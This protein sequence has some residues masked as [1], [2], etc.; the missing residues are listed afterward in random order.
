[1]RS[2]GRS[3][4][5][6]DHTRVALNDLIHRTGLRAHFGDTLPHALSECG[7]DP[8]AAIEMDFGALIQQALGREQF[9]ERLSAFLHGAPADAVGSCHQESRKTHHGRALIATTCETACDWAGCPDDQHACPPSTPAY[10]DSTWACGYYGASR[11]GDNNCDGQSYQCSCSPA[12]NTG[13]MLS[14]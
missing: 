14:R 10:C 4:V 7:Q 2:S 13:L 1:M 6:P 11:C 8:A 3:S 9:T 5:I 12:P